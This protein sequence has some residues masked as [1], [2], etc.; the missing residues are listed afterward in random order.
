MEVARAAAQGHVGTLLVQGDVQIPGIFLRD[1]G[2]IA[3]A[4]L[5]NPHAD[6]VL[7]ELAEI[8]LKQDGQVLI[9]PKQ[10]MPTDTGVAAIYRY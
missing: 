5:D 3:P 10:A 1:D 9:L 8:V 4:A 7:N 2:F 6:D